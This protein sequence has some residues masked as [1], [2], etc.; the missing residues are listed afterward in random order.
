M[1]SR[2]RR[3]SASRR[4]IRIATQIPNPART[5]IAAASVGGG[6]LGR[7]R[8]LGENGDSLGA[9]GEEAPRD[10]VGELLSAGELDAHL[11]RLLQQAQQRRVTGQHTEL[12]LGGP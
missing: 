2:R 10:V 1:S 3:K 12:T 5:R 8:T 6:R 7:R 11:R 4:K 9:D